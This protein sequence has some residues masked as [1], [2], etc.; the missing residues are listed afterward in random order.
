MP[1][2][3]RA[4]YRTKD[5]SWREDGGVCCLC[6]CVAGCM[7]QCTSAAANAGWW[8]PER[9]SAWFWPDALWLPCDGGCVRQYVPRGP[10]RM[11]WPGS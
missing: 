8:Q 5:D 2:P 3:L 11:S 7:L 6:A 10:D 9:R 4:D 1:A